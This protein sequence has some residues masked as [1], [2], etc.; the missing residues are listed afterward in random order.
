LSKTGKGG[1]EKT[2][3]ELNPVE[4]EDKNDRI[5]Q[6]LV[7]AMG[8][9]EHYDT[10]CDLE[11][12]NCH[13]TGS[14]TCIGDTDFRK[15]KPPTKC[16]ECK[17]D[18]KIIKQ[19]KGT[20]R[21][22]L[23][24]ETTQVNPQT[25]TAYLF[26]R[27]C[28]DVDVSQ[29]IDFRGALRSVKKHERDNTYQR[30]F[31][32]NQVR[33]TDEKTKLPSELEI[34]KFKEVTDSELI[35]SF[36][37]NIRGMET[38]KEGLLISILGGV[39]RS[40]DIRGTINMLMVGDPGTAK[41]K[42]LEFI[43]KVSSPSAYASGRSASAAGL[44]AGVDNLADSTRVARAGIMIL[45]NGGVIALDEMDK[46]TP[47]DRSACHE[48]MSTNHFSLVKIGINRVWEVITT[49]IGAANPY[50]GNKY[51]I[52]ISIKDNIHMPDSLLS[53][54]AL[55]FLVLDIPDLDEDKA[56]AR[57]I[58]KVRQGKIISPLTTEQL[59]MYLNY[60]KTFKPIIS[61]EAADYLM[62]WWSKLRQESQP[63]QTP[64]V[65]HRVMEDLNRLTE[66]YAKKRFCN[67]AN[68][69]DAENAISLLTTSL[70]TLKM[71]TPGERAES[72]TRGMNQK[73][74]FVHTFNKPISEMQAVL[75]LKK[76][77]KWSEEKA[78]GE[79][80]K[81]KIDGLIVEGI[82]GQLVWVK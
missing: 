51:D 41:T 6:G 13:Y 38:L 69:E 59:M 77:N 32:I 23:M 63:K 1:T 67:E 53:R 3:S 81:C 62:E 30:I 34:K 76:R 47:T 5:L 17:I 72:S 71:N 66:A 14:Y 16:K 24:Q 50:G 39:D 28:I 36:A 68:L 70:H 19:S 80:A 26:H 56:I 79:I 8:D 11:C 82:E 9:I 75:N 2:F 45:C 61:D 25:I 54:F 4:D 12:P 74:F 42:L 46:M 44:L 35:S 21:K 65:D 48:A 57:H 33:L 64:D 55:V 40:D 37:P 73:Q 10:A 7:V 27:Q 60:A 31:D 58:N 78:I 20:L 49:V 18:L 29:K 22:L 15:Y 43:V 52:D